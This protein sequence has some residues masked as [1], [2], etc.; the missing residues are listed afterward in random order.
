[1]IDLMEYGYQIEGVSNGDNIVPFIF[2][3]DVSFVFQLSLK[4][5]IMEAVYRHNEFNPIIKT[6]MVENTVSFSILLQSRECGSDRFQL[7]NNSID[8]E[9]FPS[10]LQNHLREG[11]TLLI[12]KIPTKKTPLVI[13]FSLHPIL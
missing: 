9:L 4:D 7:G 13:A 8:F 10:E 5:A 3:E 2:R 12:R 1:M 11:K 6:S